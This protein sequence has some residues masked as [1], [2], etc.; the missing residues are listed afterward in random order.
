MRTSTRG[1]V[2]IDVTAFLYARGLRF[3]MRL[4]TDS[5]AAPLD[6]GTSSA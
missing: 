5:A 3:S 2:G 1:S 4:I 6:S